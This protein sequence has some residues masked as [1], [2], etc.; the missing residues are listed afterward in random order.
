[1]RDF[2]YAIDRAELLRYLGYRGQEISPELDSL[3]DGISEKCLESAEARYCFEVFPVEPGPVIQGVRLLGE[4]IKRHLE[5][6]KF[7]AVMA[8]T[9]GFSVERAMMRLGQR[10]TAAEVIFNAACTALIEAVSDRCEGEIRRYAG[11]RGLVTS[12]RYSPGY[13]DFPLTQQPDILGLI[14]ADTRLGITLT[15]SMLM[16]PKKS[17]SALIGLYPE[18]SGV[19]RGGTSCERCENREFCEFRKEGYGCGG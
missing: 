15:N 13:G 12:F 4:D 10:S 19:K 6:A 14:G 9:L 16:L 8:A 11:E 1:M 7:C 17:V 5:G 2:E 18:S 3:I